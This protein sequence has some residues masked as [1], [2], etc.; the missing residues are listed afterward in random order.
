[1]SGSC[2]SL[3]VGT[4]KIQNIS[5]PPP[6]PGRIRLA[7][8]FVKSRGPTSDRVLVIVYSTR[9]DRAYYHIGRGIQ[10]GKK[11][12]NISGLPGDKYY[13]LVFPF[14][15]NGKPFERAANQPISV[16]VMASRRQNGTCMC[17]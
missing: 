4:H 11:Y 17:D 8:D 12:T 7:W 1:M 15:E 5:V 9:S 3:H 13:V 6:R 2:T 16:H 14:E 10:R